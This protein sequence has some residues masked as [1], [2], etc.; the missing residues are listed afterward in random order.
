MMFT[1][2]SN[3]LPNMDQ[4]RMKILAVLERREFAQARA[5][6]ID[7]G[8]DPGVPKPSTLV[9]P[10][11]PPGLPAPIETRLNRRSRRRCRRP[12]GAADLD[13]TG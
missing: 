5:D 6:A 3:A 11:G 8:D 1:S 4:G 10:P 7:V 2:V 12:T 13:E 9:R